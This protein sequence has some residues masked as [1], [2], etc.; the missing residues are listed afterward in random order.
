MKKLKLHFFFLFGLLLF[1]VSQVGNAQC[2]GFSLDFDEDDFMPGDICATEAMPNV[3]PIMTDI[4]DVYDASTQSGGA[5]GTG[6]IQLTYEAV[7]SYPNACAAQDGDFAITAAWGGNPLPCPGPSSGSDFGGTT[8]DDCECVNGYI[9]MTVDF[10][11]GFSST[12]SGFNFDWSS[13]NGS[14]EGYEYGIGFVTAGTDA[15][16]APL[17][18]LNTAAAVTGLIPSYCNAQY[19]GGTTISQYAIASPTGVFTMQG[20]DLNA[21][22]NV[23]GTSGQNG[24]DTGSGTGPNGGGDAGGVSGLAAT[25]IITQVTFIYG[26]SNAPGSDCPDDGVVGDTGVGTN[27][28]GSFSGID[29][30]VPPPPCGFPEPTVMLE[31]DCGNFNIVVGAIDE[32][33]A[34]GTG[35]TVTYDTAFSDPWT[36]TNPVT[37]AENL[38]A[39]GMTQIW[40]N[41]ADAADGACNN[42]FGPFTAPKGEVPGCDAGGAFPANPSN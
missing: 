37:G 30:C 36:G 29:L 21:S 35:T 27:P 24:E 16:G 18:G 19:A 4:I 8:S 12:V 34:S 1:G 33:G 42:T 38:A 2:D 9:V 14:S 41:V 11:N 23:C 3:G 39:D 13:I 7:V 20:D 22:I 5:D 25:D 28:S 6:D 40:I 17:A 15:L 32:S 10:L 26:L 31:E